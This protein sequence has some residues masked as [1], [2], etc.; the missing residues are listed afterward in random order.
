[1]G[2]MCMAKIQEVIPDDAHNSR[3]IFDVE[4]LQ[5]VHNCDDY[6]VFANERQ[7]P[8]KLEYVNDTYLME[9]GDTN[10][11]HDSSDMSN[12]RNG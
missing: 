6:K 8:E 3:P 4:P 1:S 7:H 2:Y 5:K 9:Q 10:I 11:I 12:M